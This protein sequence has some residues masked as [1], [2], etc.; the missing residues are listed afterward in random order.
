LLVALALVLPAAA[1]A[2]PE[3]AGAKDF[4]L[5]KRY[6]GWRLIG[7]DA[8]AVDGFK[9]MLGAPRVADRG[10]PAAGARKGGEGRHRRRPYPSPRRGGAS[11]DVF[12]NSETDPGAKVFTVL[13]KCSGEDE[14]ESGGTSVG[15]MLYP[16]THTLQNS[17][18]SQVAF[19]VPVEPR[20]LA[21]S[22][23]R[24]EGD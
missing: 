18:L 3:V 23:S 21:A 2:Q 9:L 22:L 5:I 11:P 16:P 7:Y 13:F 6:E 24:P 8:K 1:A 4:P 14:C 19:N 15:R 20:Y 12:R 17:Q 10:Q